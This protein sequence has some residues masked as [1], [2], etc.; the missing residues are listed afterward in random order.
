MDLIV[1]YIRHQEELKTLHSEGIRV[2][3][4]GNEKCL[5]CKAFLELK[6][7]PPVYEAPKN[8]QSGILGKISSVMFP[9][10]ELSIMDS[11]LKHVQSLLDNA[12]SSNDDRL[13]THYQTVK[14]GILQR[15]NNYINS[16][17]SEQYDGIDSVFDSKDE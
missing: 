7:L 5:Q 2:E 10:C 13:I 3:R 8:E 15:R 1:H 11:D 6:Y 12:Y 9:D 17:S 16:K 4:V 14:G